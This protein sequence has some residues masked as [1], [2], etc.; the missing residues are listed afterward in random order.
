MQP[1]RYTR[2]RDCWDDFVNLFDPTSILIV[3][4][5][6]SANEEPIKNVTSKRL[7]EEM[8][9]RGVKAELLKANLVC[10]HLETIVRKGDCVMFLGAG[11]IGTVYH[12]FAKR[13][14]K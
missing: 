11:D 9:A 12:E 10:Q 14:V 6:Y 5:V 4:P 3:L 2:L 8:H 1:H 13:F 7:V